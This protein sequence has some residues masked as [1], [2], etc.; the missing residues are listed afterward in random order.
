MTEKRSLLENLVH[1]RV[2]QIVGMYIAAIWLVIDNQSDDAIGQHFSGSL[3]AIK[4]F[5]N[6]QVALKVHNDYP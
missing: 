1:R 4:H 2:P 6:D 5:T 3:E